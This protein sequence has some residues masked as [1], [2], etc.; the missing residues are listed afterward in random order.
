LSNLR[1]QPA[2]QCSFLDENE[3]VVRIE[4]F[5]CYDDLDVHREAI[6]PMAKTLTLGAATARAAL[7]TFLDVALHLE[8]STR[9]EA[10][11]ATYGL[12]SK[13]QGQWYFSTLK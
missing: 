11:A 12:R 1:F 9:A 7:P 10:L 8:K 13:H 6:T 2:S 3:K 4:A 5:G